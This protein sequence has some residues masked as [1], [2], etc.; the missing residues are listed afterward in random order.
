MLDMRKRV[1]FIL[2]KCFVCERCVT[3][4]KENVEPDKGLSFCGQMEIMKSFSYL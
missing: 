2:A 1:I 3:K 4:I